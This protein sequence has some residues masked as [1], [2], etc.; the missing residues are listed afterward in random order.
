MAKIPNSVIEDFVDVVDHHNFKV[1]YRTVTGMVLKHPAKLNIDA[2]DKP[3]QER[4][5]EKLMRRISPSKRIG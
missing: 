4:L 3:A 2:L 5:R 1:L